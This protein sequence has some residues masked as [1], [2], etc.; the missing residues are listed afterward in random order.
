MHPNWSAWQPEDETLQEGAAEIAAHVGEHYKYPDGRQLLNVKPI[1][2]EMAVELHATRISDLSGETVVYKL[3]GSGADGALEG[4]SSAARLALVFREAL[5]L[6]L[7]T[8]RY[9][10]DA[11]GVMVLLPPPPAKP[12]DAAKLQAAM[13]SAATDPKA[14][15]FVDQAAAKEKLKYRAVYF[16]PG[17]LRAELEVPLD[18]TVPAGAPTADSITQ[19]EQELLDA[20]VRSNFFLW[21]SNVT[22]PSSTGPLAFKLAPL[23]PATP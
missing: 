19:V 3:E 15:E 5:E 9:L 10:R 2:G 11:E 14:A 12:S 20:R 1:A 18:V 17:D 23:P 8:F 21:Q 22:D 16:R 13:T 4:E 6:S 7:Y